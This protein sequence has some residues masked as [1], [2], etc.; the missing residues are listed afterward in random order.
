MLDNIDGFQLVS[1][2]KDKGLINGN[3]EK[4]WG[5][6]NYLVYKE[7]RPRLFHIRNSSDILVKNILFKDSPYW[8]FYAEDVI[9]ME[10][11]DTDIDVRRTDNNYH[12]L[13]D[14]TAFNTDGFD[15][16]GKNIYIHDVNIWNQDDC[17][18]VKSQDKK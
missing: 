16:S 3:G 6:M 7:N 15:I 2:N 13:Y 10:V 18:A 14:L 12:S 9:D 4:W 11:M 5:I 8:T 17:I 1:N